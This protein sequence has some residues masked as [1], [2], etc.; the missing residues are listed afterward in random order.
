MLLRHQFLVR[1]TASEHPLSDVA[2]IGTGYRL[3]LTGLSRKRAW[4]SQVTGPSVANMPESTTLP[5]ALSP[6][7]GGDLAAA[8]T[9]DEP[10]GIRNGR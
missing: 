3:P 1:L 10:M 7:H 9:T 8:F 2:Q 6:R 5:D 4:I